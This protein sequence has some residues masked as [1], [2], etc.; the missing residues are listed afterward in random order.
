MQM[1]LGLP[2]NGLDLRLRG[3]WSGLV[4]EIR[5]VHPMIKSIYQMTFTE[6][7]A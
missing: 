6:S 3:L 2:G 1:P 7:V 4:K 5:A